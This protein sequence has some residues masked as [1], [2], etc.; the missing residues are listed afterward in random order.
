MKKKH[1]RKEVKDLL[2]DL[3]RK[4]IEALEKSYQIYADGADLD[5]EMTQKVDDLSQQS[6]STESAMSIQ[7]RINNANDE[8]T[9]FE[10]LVPELA[11]GV[12]EG[13]IVFTDVIN[14][15]IG[16][17]FQDFEWDDEKFLGITTDAPIY[18]VL[19]GK[20][21]GDVIEFNG[22]TYTIEEII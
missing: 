22:T 17:A 11:D 13:N 8:L 9:K 10:N 21:E 3:K 7:N 19:Q 1:V 4:E 20:N 15:V 12:T 5:E 18:E 6:V 14:L 16:L 2:I